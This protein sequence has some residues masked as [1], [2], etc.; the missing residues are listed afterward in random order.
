MNC[1]LARLV[2]VETKLQSASFM[3]FH[4]RIGSH[5]NFTGAGTEVVSAIVF[6]F[7]YWL[8]PPI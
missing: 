5:L 1:N 3:I 2:Y 4:N 7:R 8:V 6:F